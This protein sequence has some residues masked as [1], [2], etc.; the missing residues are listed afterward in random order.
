MTAIAPRETPAAVKEWCSSMMEPWATLVVSGQ[1][2]PQA[3]QNKMFQLK[4]RFGRLPT[5]Y[6]E[7]IRL[8][9]LIG[10]PSPR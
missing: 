1:R 2:L 3:I 8:D 7:L 9:Q 10:K 6:S 4:A 5:N